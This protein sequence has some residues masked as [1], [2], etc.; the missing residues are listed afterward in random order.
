M[1]DCCKDCGEKKKGRPKHKKWFSYLLY[2]IIG[3]IV[4]WALV[5]QIS[6]D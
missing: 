3:A 4:L 5:L 2:I 1:K 6:N